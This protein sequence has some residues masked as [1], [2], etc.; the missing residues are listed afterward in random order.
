MEGLPVHRL[1]YWLDDRGIPVR[2]SAGDF[3][4]L[5]SVE[6]GCEIHEDPIQWI[7]GIN[8]QKHE[9]DNVWSYIFTPPISLH[10]MR[11]RLQR[12]LFVGRVLAEH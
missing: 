7:P 12:V 3:Y 8:Q 6:T 11:R 9:D 1:V 4:L 5:Q 2:F 10:G